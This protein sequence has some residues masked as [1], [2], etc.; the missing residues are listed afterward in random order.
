MN[1]L[2][3]VFFT[4]V[5]LLVVGVVVLMVTQVMTKPVPV[6]FALGDP[7][8][9]FT[10]DQGEDLVQTVDPVDATFNTFT[11]AGDSTDQAT[12]HLTGMGTATRL[13]SVQLALNP[14]L[15]SDVKPRYTTIGL[16]QLEAYQLS[17][18]YTNLSLE[19]CTAERYLIFA[20]PGKSGLIASFEFCGAESRT[21]QRFHEQFVESI[22]WGE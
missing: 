3:M 10:Y 16:Q 1:R 22:A 2:Q 9:S 21:M 4:L 13:T 8:F 5:V 15:S 18:A 7:P 14:S 20:S 17:L 6:E 11:V 19:S 12:F